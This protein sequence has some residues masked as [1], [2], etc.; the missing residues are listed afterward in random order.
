VLGSIHPQDKSRQGR[1]KITQDEI[2]GTGRP[3]AE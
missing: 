3:A 2:L 1:P